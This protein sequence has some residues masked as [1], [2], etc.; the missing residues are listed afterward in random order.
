MNGR[1][2]GIPIS[3][4]FERIDRIGTRRAQGCQSVVYDYFGK[5]RDNFFALGVWC[6]W[7]M[8]LVEPAGLVPQE[9]FLIHERGKSLLRVLLRGKGVECEILKYL[10]FSEMLAKWVT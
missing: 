2:L 8:L 6:I 9:P 7:W 10:D 5:I 3:E 1:W 4:N